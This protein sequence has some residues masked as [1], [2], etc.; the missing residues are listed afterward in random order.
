MIV[1]PQPTLRGDCQNII[2]SAGKTSWERRSK[3][4]KLPTAVAAEIGRFRHFKALHRPHESSDR[5][6]DKP[7]PVQSRQADTLVEKASDPFTSCRGKCLQAH[8]IGFLKTLTGGEA[9]VS[10]SH[11]PHHLR[12]RALHVLEQLCGLA[13]VFWHRRPRPHEPSSRPP[14]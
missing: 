9:P 11:L 1:L 13:N 6:S 10:S 14:C 4:R 2:Y 5:P 12:T 7:S 3:R 8:I